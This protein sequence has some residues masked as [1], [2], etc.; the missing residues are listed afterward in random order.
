MINDAIEAEKT[1][2]GAERMS[3]GAQNTGG[4]LEWATTGLQNG[5]A[6]SAK[7]ACRVYDDAPA[8][9][10]DGYPMSDCALYYGW[11]A[12][13]VAGPFTQP[14]FRF[15][16]GAVAVHIHSFSANT[17]RDPNANWVAPLLTKGAAASSAMFTSRICS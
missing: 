9:F 8:I 3:I 2:C 11:Y 4:G 12:G 5:G 15:V 14:D 7:P 10:P 13:G 16:P 1:G 17:L 6:T